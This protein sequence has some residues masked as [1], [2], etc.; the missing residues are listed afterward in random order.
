MGDIS[1]HSFILG[2]AFHRLCKPPFFWF[3]RVKAWVQAITRTSC[4]GLDMIHYSVS[5]LYKIIYNFHKHTYMLIECYASLWT[6]T[7]RPKSFHP[8]WPPNLWNIS[9]IT[10]LGW[11]GWSAS[12]HWHCNGHPH[13]WL[14]Q[15]FESRSESMEIC[16][17]IL[18]HTVL[19]I[20]KKVQQLDFAVDICQL[21]GIS[22][23]KI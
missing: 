6:L 22:M 23:A 16:Q 17:K 9:T 18:I 20:R 21:E 19:A 10:F 11:D 1:P 4:Q 15:T 7:R 3:A 8:F 2:Q 12:A 5:I 14:F 13:Q